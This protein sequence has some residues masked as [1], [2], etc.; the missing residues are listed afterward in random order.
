MKYFKF[1]K[2]FKKSENKKVKKQ[3][4][5]K[6][7]QSFA[8]K[9]AKDEHKWRFWMMLCVGIYSCVCTFFIFDLLYKTGYKDGNFKLD[10]TVLIAL[11]GTFYAS[12]VGLTYII[13]RGLFEAEEKRN[14]L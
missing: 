12:I 1:W 2:I 8:L 7:E 13:L 14:K 6:Q 5:T 10:S 11:L 3:S 9:K 4:H